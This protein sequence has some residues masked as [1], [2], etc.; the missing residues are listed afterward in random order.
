MNADDRCFPNHL[1]SP[2]PGQQPEPATEAKLPQTPTKH[3]LLELEKLV[4]GVLEASVEEM[5]MEAI[6]L[7]RRAMKARRTFSISLALRALRLEQGLRAAQQRVIELQWELAQFR[8]G[9]TTL[10][11]TAGEVED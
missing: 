6:V 8:R 9:L 10:S 11:P 2:L 5:D 1:G 7:V 3:Y 4:R